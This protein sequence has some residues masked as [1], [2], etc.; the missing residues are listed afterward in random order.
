MTS[1]T[2]EPLGMDI[3]N[4]ANSTYEETGVGDDTTIPLSRCD[5]TFLIHVD[6]VTHLHQAVDVAALNMIRY[7]LDSFHI[8]ATDPD[9]GRRW[10]LRDG[11]VFPAEELLAEIEQQRES[12]GLDADNLTGMDLGIDGDQDS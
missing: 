2:P 8:L 10:I 9:T 5:L 4:D 7:G 12:D 11:Q 6:D 1:A 3:S